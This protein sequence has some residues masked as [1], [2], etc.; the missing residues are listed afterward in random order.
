MLICKKLRKLLGE[1]PTGYPS[2]SLDKGRLM[3]MGRLVISHSSS[4]ISTLLRVYHD[5]SLGG[6]SS[7]FKTY[8][9]VAAEWYWIGMKR[10]IQRY[11]GSF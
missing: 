1:Q 3:Y 9:R 8:K 10:D 2:F 4:F 5:N 7:E 6:H 11:V